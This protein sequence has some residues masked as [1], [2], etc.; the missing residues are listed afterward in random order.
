MISASETYIGVANEGITGF[1]T[2]LG[3]GLV[4]TVTKPAIGVLDLAT[5]AATAVKESSKSFYKLIPPRL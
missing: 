2:G 3:W 4:G 5:G 1:F